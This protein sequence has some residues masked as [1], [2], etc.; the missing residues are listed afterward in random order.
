MFVIYVQCDCCEEEEYQAYRAWRETRPCALE[1]TAAG[2]HGWKESHCI[3]WEIEYI[4]LGL[5]C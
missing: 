5:V 4:L 2:Q 3:T 1:E